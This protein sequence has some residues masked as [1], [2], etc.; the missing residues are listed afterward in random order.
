MKTQCSKCT[1]TQKNAA[2]RVVERLQAEYDK[3][4]QQLLEKWDPKRELSAK[5]AEFMKEEKKKG[6][7]KF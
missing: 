1:D 2:L 7:S 3:E 5:F 4:W 6:F